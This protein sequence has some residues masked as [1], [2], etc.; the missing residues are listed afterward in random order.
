MFVDTSAPPKLPTV[1]TLLLQPQNLPLEFRLFEVFL[2][3]FLI[4]GILQN[5]FDATFAPAFPLHL[6]FWGSNLR[7]GSYQLNT[8]NRVVNLYFGR[9]AILYAKLRIFAKKRVKECQDR[10]TSSSKIEIKYACYFCNNLFHFNYEMVGGLSS[11]QIR[12]NFKI[13]FEMDSK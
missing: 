7:K 13:S 11:N 12:L 2:V 9:F 10:R 1:T 6:Q 8:K 5:N 4:C 3:A